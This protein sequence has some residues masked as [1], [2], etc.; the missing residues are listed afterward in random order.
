MGSVAMGPRAWV[1]TFSV[2]CVV[3][4]GAA[5]QSRDGSGSDAP[6]AVDRVQPNDATASDTVLAND[7]PADDVAPAD[8]VVATDTAADDAS[9]PETGASDAATD[10]PPAMRDPPAL[11]PYSRGS[12]P[13][14]IG[15]ATTDTSLNTGFATGAQRRQFR[16]IVPRTYDGSSD[17]PVVFMW[18]WMNASSGSFIRD[19]ELESAT[20][21]MHFIAVL[22]DALRDAAGNRVYQ[23]NWPFVEFWGQDG[24]IQ[25]FDDLLTCVSSQYRVDRRRVHGVGVSAGGLW[26][27]FLSTT[28]RANYFASIES[29]SGGLG[30]VPFAWRMLYRPQVNK[31]PALVLWGG[32][33][34]WLIVDFNQASMRFRDE[35]RR[36][37]HFVVTCTHT[38]GHALPPIPAPP[39]GGTRF[40]PLW[41]FLLD[42]P[43]GLPPDDSPYRRTGLP[44][45]YPSWCAIAP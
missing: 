15:G 45:S 36:D 8:D 21:Q 33:S 11:R 38:T 44:A 34:D 42:H 14:L 16:L 3:G 10:A 23:L 19:G 9:A 1:V 13:T 20:E 41:Q 17:W 5:V 2:A 24:E 25:F 18:H 39:D 27:T 26:L 40:R 22:P 4:C 35:L 31:F 32:T 29:L 43:Y 28:D 7:S 12:C 37:H 30:E 6:V